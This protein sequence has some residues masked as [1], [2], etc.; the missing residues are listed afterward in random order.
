MKRYSLVTAFML[1]ITFI[2]L[3][4]PLPAQQI[5]DDENRPERKS[6]F[7]FG[8]KV[9]YAW[10]E[11]VWG[12]M[13]PVELISLL[14]YRYGATSV[15]YKGKASFLYNPFISIGLGKRWYLSMSYSYGRY[16]GIGGNA[17]T[18][19]F[20]R[21]TFLFSS[22]TP[23]QKHVINHSIRAEKH[24]ADMLFNRHLT[25][26]CKIF[27][28]LKYQGYT[29]RDTIRVNL[30]QILT[31]VSTDWSYTPWRFKGTMLF[32]SFGGGLGF[33]FTV[34]IVQNLFLLPN[35]S[36]L[37]LIGKDYSPGSSK[38]H[39]LIQNLFASTDLS[40]NRKNYALLG[41]IGSLSF[42]YLIPA[43]HLT[44]DAGLRA[45]CLYYTD[46]PKADIKRRTEL[47]WGPYLGVTASF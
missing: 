24:D 11:P 19:P 10:W 39:T 28:G 14:H 38:F 41:G 46:K 36:G 18:F 25:N 32:H 45:Q 17:Y 3:A 30:A 27:F 13:E 29:M 33:G 37:I 35:V 47:F 26:W 16:S 34:H 8:L 42:A 20:A 15:E 44:L 22:T 9:H 43:A 2:L 31:P 12:K 6:S 40:S 7:S 23:A 1:S 21:G 5:I 4:L